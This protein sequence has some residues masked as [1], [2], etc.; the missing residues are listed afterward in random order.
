[1]TP[2]VEH[3]ADGAVIALLLAAGTAI[4]LGVAST[5]HAARIFPPVSYLV[6]E[7]GLTPHHPLQK[8]VIY[9]GRPFFAYYAGAREIGGGVYEVRI[10]LRPVR[11]G[12]R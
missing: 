9:D 6:R 5:A 11:S 4:G 8:G 10:R 1:M 7:F 2:R 12:A 3:I